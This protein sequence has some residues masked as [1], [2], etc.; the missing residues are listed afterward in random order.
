MASTQRAPGI[1]RGFGYLIRGAHFVY[2]RHFDLIR[3]WIW[4]VIITLAVIV[5]V[6]VG[7]WFAREP[8][9][10][11][12]WPSPEG[13]TVAV[14]VVRV[15]HDLV[16]IL[17]MLVIWI[18]GLIGSIAISAV[19]AAPFNDMLSEAVELLARGQAAPPFSLSELAFGAARSLRIEAAKFAFFAAIMGPLFV[20]S[21]FVPVIGSVVYPVL[22][23]LLGALY[24]GLDY[25]DWPASRRHLGARWRYRF[26]GRHFWALLGLGLGVWIVLFLPLFNLFLMPAAVAGGTLMFLDIE[27]LELESRRVSE[28]STASMEPQKS[29]S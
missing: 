22:A 27:H 10:D 6:L 24:F 28:A 21:F 4:P 15:L 1:V 9:I 5:G 13:E 8:L 7:G 29:E 20:V 11:W 19:F 23:F 3:Y 14:A 26:V 25:V 18:A 2:V 17:L 12:I 16:G